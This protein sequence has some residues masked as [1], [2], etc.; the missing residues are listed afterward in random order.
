MSRNP[1]LSATSG[2]MRWLAEQFGG[3]AERGLDLFDRDA[4]ALAGPNGVGKRLGELGVSSGLG[5]D[6]V[7]R[8]PVAVVADD[9]GKEARDVLHVHPR[10]P[11]PA[12]AEHD[13]C[14]LSNGWRKTGKAPPSSTHSTS[15]S[16]NNATRISPSSLA[17]ASCSQSASIAPL[18]RSRDTGW[19]S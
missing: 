17:A 19:S 18:T 15:P 9:V 16:L 3:A 4:G 10:H 6:E 7:D 11:L 1:R 8:A 5:T 13:A 12:G 14:P 2:V